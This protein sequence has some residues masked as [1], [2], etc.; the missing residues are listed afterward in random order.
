MNWASRVWVRLVIPGSIGTGAYGELDANRLSDVSA[1]KPFGE[2]EGLPDHGEHRFGVRYVDHA[3][4][5]TV[6]PLGMS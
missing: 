2:F 6:P 1:R 3:K 5:G 4:P